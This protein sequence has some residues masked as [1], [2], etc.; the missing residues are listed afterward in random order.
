MDAV[1]RY[2]QFHG[3]EPKS[4]R[5]IR[6]YP[7]KKLVVL[8]RAVAIEYRCSKYNGG[9]DGRSAVY[10]HEFETP[11]ELCMDESGRQFLYL[12]GKNIIVDDEGIK[13]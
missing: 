13:N 3:K 5:Q 1:D 11:V 7:S 2:R 12:I 10:R 6:A 4:A 9:G 8:G